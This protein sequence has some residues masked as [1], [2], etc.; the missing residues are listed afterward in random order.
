MYRTDQD[1][2]FVSEYPDN[3]TNYY[4]PHPV[5]CLVTIWLTANCLSA[6]H[7]YP[8]NLTLGE[9]EVLDNMNLRYETYF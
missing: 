3:C 2:I 5:D 4:G 6:G 9:L 7:K 8:Y 1:S